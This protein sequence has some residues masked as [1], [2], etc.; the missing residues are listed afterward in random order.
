MKKIFS[1]ILVSASALYGLSS[2]NAQVSGYIGDAL[3]YSQPEPVTGSARIQ[4]MGGTQ[5]ALGGDISSAFSN[6]AGLGFFN[7][8][9]LSIS[10]T[11]SSNRNDTQY[12]GSNDYQYRNSF[13]LSNLG[14]VFQN[15]P[16]QSNGGWLGGSFAISYQRVNN[17]NNNISYQ[18]SN[19]NNT[20]VDSFLQYDDQTLDTFR[21]AEEIS[22]TL[23]YNSF[24]I[25][26]GFY[27]LENSDTIFFYDTYFPVTDEEYPV[28]QMESIRT[29][30]SQG[31]WNFSY[32]GNF[33]DK[34]Y[35]GG[36]IGISSIDYR[37]QS[38]YTETVNENLYQDHPQE[39]LDYPNQRIILEEDVRQRGSGI[40]ATIGAIARPI[41]QLSI[42]F[43]YRTPTFY[44]IEETAD[45]SY[46]TI[47]TDNTE[48]FAEAPSVFDFNI[49]SAGKLNAGLAYFFE[50]YGLVT[51]DIEYTDYGNTRLT[52]PQNYLRSDNQLIPET[53]KSV[54]NYRVGGEFRYEILRFR[55]GYAK[56]N[57]PYN[58]ENT[59]T[60]G[61]S[62]FSTGLG[63]RLRN[64]YGDLAVVVQN[65]QD[66]YN[67]YTTDLSRSFDNEGE[68]IFTPTTSPEVRIDN[69]KTRA[70]IT[71]GFNF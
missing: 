11:F 29:T 43:S 6:P 51:A 59:Q 5:T 56:Q 52:D 19:P 68:Q 18:G 21:D 39:R 16:S 49:R 25:D 70:V 47:F 15:S 8:S 33:D 28:R 37:R 13:N 46:H 7:R 60:F 71:V 40:N 63:L 45:L 27:R 38:T 48:E 20:F 26:D 30:G 42:G 41:D 57:S 3:R 65:R 10:P 4:A 12:F 23:A 55:L 34:L 44:N 54:I 31:Q 35:I 69:R 2:A 22:T 1:L 66:S 61:L 32:G 9:E 17:F 67:P 50:K 64:F 24:L 36:G 58:T 53:L 62:S 14:L